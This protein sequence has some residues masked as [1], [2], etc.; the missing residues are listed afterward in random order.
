MHLLSSLILLCLAFSPCFGQHTSN[1]TQS[2]DS[3]RISIIQEGPEQYTVKMEKHKNE[4]TMPVE[5]GSDLKGVKRGF[6]GTFSGMFYYRKFASEGGLG[7][8]RTGPKLDGTFKIESM[9][10]KQGKQLCSSHCPGPVDL[11]LIV[12]K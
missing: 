11:T 1:L 4:Q 3:A 10:D 7:T 9:V 6:I 8:T 5:V 2:P 12:G